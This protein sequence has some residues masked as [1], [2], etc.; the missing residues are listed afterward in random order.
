MIDDQ[1]AEEINQLKQEKQW[2]KLDQLYAN[3]A[4]AALDFEQR[5]F[6]DWERATL[7]ATELNDPAGAINVLENAVHLGGPLEVIAP[8]IEA[9]RTAAPDNHK[10]QLQA[11]NTYQQLLQTSQLSRMTVDLKAWLKQTE[12][13]LEHMLDSESTMELDDS[14]LDSVDIVSEEFVN[15]DLLSAQATKVNPSTSHQDHENTHQ[16]SQKPIKSAIQANAFQRFTAQF[17]QEQPLKFIKELP[18]AIKQ[19]SMTDQEEDRLEALLW[20]AASTHDQWRLWSQSYEQ[21]FLSGPDEGKHADRTFKLAS[22]LEVELK[23][24][25]RAI[26]LYSLVLK[27]NSQHDEAFDRLRSLFKTTENWDLLGKLLTN[28]SKSSVGRWPLEDRFDMC[29]EAGDYYFQYLNNSAKAITA[30]FQALE[31]NPDSKQIFVRLVE[32]YQKNNKWDASIKVL[33]KLATLEEDQTKAAFHLYSVGL[34]QKDYLKDHY[35]AVR[36]FDEALD[37]DPKFMKAFQAIDDTLDS[38]DQNQ[39]V[40]ERRDRYYRKML[41]RAV[42]HELDESMIAE[43]ALQVGKINGSILGRWQE[44]LQ[45]YELVLDYEPMRDEAHLGLIEA[46]AQIAGPLESMHGAFTWVRRRP[47]QAIAYLA[48][49]E[50][51]MQ[52]QQWD[53]AWCTAITLDAIGHVNPEVKRHLEAGKELLGSQLTRVVNTSE[54]HLLEWSGFE[55]GGNGDEWGSLLALLGQEFLSLDSKS[56]RQ[57]GFNVK[58]DLVPSDESTVVGRVAHYICKHLNLTRPMIW[59]NSPSNGSLITPVC[60]SEGYFG[61]ALNRE[62][63]AKLS[64]EELACTLTVGLM[65]T[66]TSSI[67][68]LLPNRNQL[69]YDLQDALIQTGFKREFNSSNTNTSTIPNPKRSQSI[70]NLIN[71]ISQENGAELNRL[72]QNLGSIES[73]LIAIEQTTFRA[74]LLIGSDPRLVQ[75]LM[76]GLNYISRDQEAERRY[77]LLLYSVS[78]PYL[79]LRSQLQLAWV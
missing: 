53:Q 14:V 19:Q 17:A 37:L 28:F 59:L 72:C 48:L 30:W 1:K 16:Q 38:E 6:L 29:L 24:L 42:N 23:D 34:I 43:L 62:I 41:I 61:L 54:W 57:L 25:D 18:L 60:L 56:A 3:L 77:K 31:L 52:A 67:F 10:A 50:R 70:Q 74:S 12:S 13:R 71:T 64:I 15:A 55:W 7:L 40:V 45:A 69:L 65:L 78:P 47:Q 4:E 2:T 79:K 49:F 66:Q 20:R 9:I 76:Q 39:G 22:I 44:A 27:Y 68:A 33:R 36:S 26:E 8:Q 73:W 32:I 5:L 63:C 11:Q 51:A 35:L 21:S 75:L 58:R 46:Q